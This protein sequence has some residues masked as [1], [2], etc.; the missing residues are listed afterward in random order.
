MSRVPEQPVVQAYLDALRGELAGQLGGADIERIVE[1]VAGHLCEA[2]DDAGAR[3]ERDIAAVVARFGHTSEVG[4]AYRKTGVRA[5][6]AKDEPGTQ[7]GHTTSRANYLPTR[8]ASRPHV[9]D[10]I[11]LGHILRGLAR[12]PAF[13][14]VTI[15][16][17]AIGI[18]ANAVILS[19][20]NGI[21][22]Q[23][24]P[25]PNAD[26]LVRV[27]HDAPGLNVG[28]DD[29]GLSFRTYFF[30][31]DS[32]VLEDL[33]IYQVGARNLSGGDEPQRIVSVS[34][35]HSFFDTLGVPPAMGRTFNLDDEAEGATPVVILSDE[36]WRSN[37]GGREDVLGETVLMD[38][39]SVEIVGVMPPRLNFP[40]R[41]MGLFEPIT[42][43][44]NAPG[45][46]GSLGTNSVGRPPPG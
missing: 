5:I 38:G 24:L 33:A 28:M 6:E 43:D 14:L 35:S 37:F 32:G 13:T 20:V 30:F 40:Q 44:P 21:L 46:L 2:I 18:G 27:Y 9:M 26:R 29:I 22:L 42:L 45:Q 3:S 19:V 11:N 39:E 34:V 4:L 17:L 10:L 36:L 8:S 7:A 25:F 23:P 15:A 31:K 16:T 41:D 1:E 12:K